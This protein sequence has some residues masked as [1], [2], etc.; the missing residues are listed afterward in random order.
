[1]QASIDLQ[2]GVVNAQ[3]KDFKTAY[4]YFF[5]A[6]EVY[7]QNDEKAQAIKAFQYMILCKMMINANDDV[8]KGLTIGKDSSKWQIWTTL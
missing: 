2:S 5:E 1:M 6:F 4:S 8:T 7:H 3:D